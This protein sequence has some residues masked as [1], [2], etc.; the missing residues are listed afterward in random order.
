MGGRKINVGRQ[1]RPVQGPPA[2]SLQTPPAAAG[3]RVATTYGKP[4]IVMEDGEKNTF[5]Y[6]EGAWQP[7]DTSIAELKQDC[8]V[9]LLPQKLNGKVRY[10]VRRP[11]GAG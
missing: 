8:Q 1:R 6:R 11:V 5:E 10:E 9:K 2:R 4:F 3:P 7:S